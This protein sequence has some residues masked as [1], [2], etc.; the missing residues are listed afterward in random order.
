M[1]GEDPQAHFAKDFQH[2]A[3]SKRNQ[4]PL[5]RDR[6]PGPVAIF[7]F[8]RPQPKE[9]EEYAFMNSHK[10]SHLAAAAAVCLIST[11]A[12][13]STQ[14][15]PEEIRHRRLRHRNQDRQR[16][17]LCGPASAYG[18]IGKTEEAYFKMIND[19]GGINGR[20]INWISYDDGYSPP[21]TVEQI[22]K[23]IESDEVFLV[24]NALARRP[25]TAVQK[26]HNAK[27][28]AAAFPRHRRQQVERPEGI[29]AG[30]IGFQPSW[31]R[32][33]DYCEY[34]LRVVPLA[35]AGG[36]EKLR[37]L[38]G[39][40]IFLHGGLGRRA[41]RVEHQKHFVALDQ[42][43]DA[44]PPSRRAVAVIVGDPVDLAAG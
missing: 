37:H 1:H 35:G 29:S 43:P 15:W 36:E 44:A 12:L 23:L 24:F 30:S 25:Q 26:Y 32:S 7:L 17:G 39:I 28:G 21:K 33:K 11:Q 8:I 34:I 5:P 19:A 16:R 9:T 40:M 4:R 18:V 6:L 38:F 14:A 42:L 41:Q 31:R 2:A 10:L 27:K 3:E 13:L 22:R 20:K